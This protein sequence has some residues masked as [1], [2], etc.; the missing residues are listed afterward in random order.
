MNATESLEAQ[1][2][3]SSMESASASANSPSAAA[4]R[5]SRQFLD[6]QCDRILAAVEASPGQSR[7]SLSKL[8]DLDVMLVGRLLA[9]LVGG[10][11]L[12]MTGS[13]KGARY[14]ARTPDAA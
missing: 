7:A 3:S 12:T 6:L 4:P 9:R 13:R 2:Q 5:S 10:G 8:L 11:T 14:Y 1:M